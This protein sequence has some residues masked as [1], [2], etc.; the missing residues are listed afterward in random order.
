[1]STMIVI[2]LPPSALLTGSLYEW[3]LASVRASANK[4]LQAPKKLSEFAIAECF[5]KNV[6]KNFETFLASLALPLLGLNASL[7]I[8]DSNAG[9]NSLSPYT[10]AIYHL[11]SLSSNR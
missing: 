8:S 7:I 3:K 9:I 6:F 4:Y 5:M 1:M 11:P 2:I 10:S